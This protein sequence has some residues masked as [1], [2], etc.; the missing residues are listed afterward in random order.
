MSDERDILDWLRQHTNPQDPTPGEIERARARLTVAIQAEKQATRRRTPRRRYLMRLVA[1]VAVAVATVVLVPVAVRQPAEAAL[2]EIA[3][4]ARQ[5]QPVDVPDGSFIYAEST[6]F[7]LVGREGDEF[8]LPGGSVAY[9]LPRTRRV[10]RSPD[11]QFVRLETTH[12]EPRFFDP[13]H[14]AAYYQLGLDRTDNIGKTIREEF[15]EIAD[16]VDE[17]QWPTNPNDLRQT[18]DEYLG[19]ATPAPAELV[20]LAVNILRERSP[21]PP[22]RAAVLEL[23]A[24]LPVDLIRQDDHTTTIGVTN[25]G[26]HQTYTLSLD[27]QLRAETATLIDGDP[28]SG[29][30]PGTQTTDIEYQ[31]VEVIQHLPR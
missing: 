13:A 3:Q 27:G 1:A 21:S 23:L 17:I 22:L 15:T 8:G 26:R 14:E 16:P 31:P 7:N 5:A 9:L 18:M 10:W 20:D 2:I 19:S 11:H 28:S 30:P 6:G 25:N 24:D 29:I 12:G 4:A